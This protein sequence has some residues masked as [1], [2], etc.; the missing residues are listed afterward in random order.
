MKLNLSPNPKPKKICKGAFT[1]IELLIV[2]AIIALLAAIL[3][4][5]FG[6]ARENARRTTCQSNLKQ[7]GLGFTMY[8]QDYDERYPNQMTT[9]SGWD[10]RVPEYLGID[11]SSTSKTPSILQC[12]NDGT[13]K[14]VVSTCTTNSSYLPRS[15]SMPYA[16]LT[17]GTPLFFA[18]KYTSADG[19]IGRLSSEIPEPSFT[20][21]IA[22]NINNVNIFRSNSDSYIGSA[23]AQGENQITP[24]NKP[25][26]A[27]LP[28][29]G[30][31][32]H[33]EG[34][35]Y[36]FVDGHVKWM[37]PEATINGSGKTAGTMAAPKGMWTVAEND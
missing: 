5:V 13:L 16:K 30:T 20:L 28:Q 36:L 15:Y 7:L 19:Y 1:L 10:I 12:P 24:A 2:I 33:F 25:L 6:R 27:D 14:R 9:S 18:G 8:A 31:P 37:K 32:V 4:P 3:F 29:Y 34:W 35:N 17:N 23:Q 21:M 11:T 26:C 22:E